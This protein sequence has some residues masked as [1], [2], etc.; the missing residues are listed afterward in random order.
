MRCSIARLGALPRSTSLPRHVRIDSA[1]Q[2]LELVAH[3][4]EPSLGVIHQAPR[5]APNTTRWDIAAVPTPR[6]DTR[7]SEIILPRW[8][9]AAADRQIRVQPEASRQDAGGRCSCRAQTSTTERCQRRTVRATPAQK[10]GPISS[11][12]AFILDL[13]PERV[14]PHVRGHQTATVRRTA[15]IL[16]PY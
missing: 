8:L 16:L 1:R 5:R 9:A 6:A 12:V 3:C 2:R 4:A 7:L 10:R 11:M 13:L 14:G 15:Q